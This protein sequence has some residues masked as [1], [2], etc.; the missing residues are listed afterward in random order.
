MPPSDVMVGFE[1]LNNFVGTL[2]HLY[3][4][5]HHSFILSSFPS[6]I[7][8]SILSFILPFASFIRPFIHPF[9]LFIR[10]FI[11]PPINHFIHSFIMPSVIRSIIF[12]PHI[13]SSFHF[14]HFI[15][16]FIHPLIILFIHPPTNHSFY[17]SFFF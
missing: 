6:F 2:G 13:H 12:Y 3:I 5:I 14:Y 1:R 10:P 8:S 17:T 11:H 4:D 15:Q 9:P 7:L 16:T